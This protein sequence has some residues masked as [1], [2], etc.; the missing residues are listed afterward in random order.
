LPEFLRLV[1]AITG[2]VTELVDALVRLGDVRELAELGR[3]LQREHRSQAVRADQAQ[4]L[5]THRAELGLRRLNRPEPE[6]WFESASIYGVDIAH[7]R[8]LLRRVAAKIR[9]LSASSSNELV[10]RRAIVNLQLIDWP[11]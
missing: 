7:V 1:Q 9:R 11:P 5:R 10:R 2:R 8:A 4:R 6:D 3:A